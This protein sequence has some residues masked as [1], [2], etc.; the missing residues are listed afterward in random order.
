MRV[1]EVT[2]DRIWR[3]FSRLLIFFDF[4]AEFVVS[5]KS[6]RVVR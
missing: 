1:L 4:N 6:E 5:E 3:V 2:E